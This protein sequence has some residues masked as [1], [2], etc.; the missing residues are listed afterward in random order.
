ML[1]KFLYTDYQYDKIQ[2]NLK[3]DIDFLF[4]KGRSI[5]FQGYSSTIR[6]NLFGYIVLRSTRNL[7]YHLQMLRV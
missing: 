5:A 4:G 3:K 7:F 2:I 6:C 1:N